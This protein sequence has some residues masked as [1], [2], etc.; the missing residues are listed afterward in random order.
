MY[1]LTFLLHNHFCPV[2]TKL[3]LHCV[4]NFVNSWFTSPL[5]QKFLFIAGVQGVSNFVRYDILCPTIIK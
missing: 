1:L 2:N 4:N 5:G 3:N